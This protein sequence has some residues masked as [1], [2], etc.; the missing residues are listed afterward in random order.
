[1]RT[2]IKT[3]MIIRLPSM[4]LRSLPI[5]TSIRAAIASQ[6]SVDLIF[7]ESFTP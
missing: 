2:S 6:G 5:S 7:I 4:T 3:N 1:M